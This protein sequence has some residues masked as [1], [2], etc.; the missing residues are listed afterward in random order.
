MSTE[1]QKAFCALM[2][3]RFVHRRILQS[4]IFSLRS[5]IKSIGY[6]PPLIKDLDELKSRITDAINL[7]TV[8]M[9]QQV[10]EEF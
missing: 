8:D 2:T 6:I 5:Y 9:L 7:L 3:L 10:Y 1:Q 4:V